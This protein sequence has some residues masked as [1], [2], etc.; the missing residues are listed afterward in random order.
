[1][2][3]QMDTLDGI[4]DAAGRQTDDIGLELHDDGWAWATKQCNRW[5]KHGHD[6]LYFVGDWDGYVDIDTGAV[7]GE[8]PI[9]DVS[10]EDD[11]V[12]Y[13][14]EDIDERYPLVSREA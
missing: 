8:T 2:S 14:A 13:Y 12:V 9:V 4:L 1:M 7:E 6:R 5:T 3:T 10:V 11:R